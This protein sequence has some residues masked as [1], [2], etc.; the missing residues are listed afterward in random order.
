[1]PD[2]NGSSRAVV[3][4]MVNGR[5]VSLPQ[6]TTVATALLC[7]GIPCRYS[8]TGEPRAPFCGMGICFEC[9]AAVDGVPHRRTCQIVC[10]E[11]MRVETQG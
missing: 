1:M 8:E 11:N 9:R 4:I 3:T 7:A 2:G 6:G 5:V 10:R